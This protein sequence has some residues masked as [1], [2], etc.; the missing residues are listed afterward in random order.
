MNKL[1]RLSV[2]IALLTFSAIAWSSDVEI[3]NVFVSGEAALASE[4][5]ENFTNVKTAVDDN[6]ARLTQ[7]ETAISQSASDISSLQNSVSALEALQPADLTRIQ[8]LNWEHYQEFTVSDYLENGVVIWFSN[9][10][11]SA[12][13]TPPNLNYHVQLFQYASN[14]WELEFDIE[15]NEVSNVSVDSNSVIT[16][17]TV[18]AGPLPDV[19]QGLQIKRIN[20]IDTLDIPGI[21]KVV[22]R[23]DFI[24]DANGRA[25]DGNFVRAE[26]PTGDRIEGGTFESIFRVSL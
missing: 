20:L 15:F 23:G 1:N 16:G 24:L 2:S 7:A 17:F 10:I 6:N 19:M 11:S 4:V 14:D 5:N 12:T 25:V 18:E 21:Y 22:I 3:P 8:Y 26:T 9:D 13:L